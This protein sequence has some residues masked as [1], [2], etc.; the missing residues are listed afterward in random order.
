MVSFS[1]WGQTRLVHDDL[2]AHVWHH[3]VLSVSAQRDTAALSVD[4][5]ILGTTKPGSP[6]PGGQVTVFLGQNL[7]SESGVSNFY[8]DGV[9]LTASSG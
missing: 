5:H 3:L 1:A 6:V 2:A 7:G 8:Y 4:G 9:S